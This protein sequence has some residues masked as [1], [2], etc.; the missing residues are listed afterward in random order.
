MIS[1]RSF[2]LVA[3]LINCFLTK[4]CLALPT[5]PPLI[6]DT[7]TVM[8]Q[9]SSEAFISAQLAIPLF[10]CLTDQVLFPYHPPPEVLVAL[11][12]PLCAMVHFCLLTLPSDSQTIQ[13]F[14]FLANHEDMV[15]M[16][17]CL[18]SWYTTVIRM[19]GWEYYKV[20]G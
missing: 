15:L 11:Y 2:P 9:R 1:T 3:L 19:R 10:R 12:R 16:T 18:K 14:P 13:R 8:P 4:A 20:S 5:K 6:Y 17:R 7:C